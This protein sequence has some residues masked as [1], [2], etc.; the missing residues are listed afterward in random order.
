MKAQKLESKRRKT[1]KIRI[2]YFRTE[3]FRK[4]GQPRA[5]IVLEREQLEVETAQVEEVD[6]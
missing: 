6:V 4:S 3:N 5:N 2:A 1:R